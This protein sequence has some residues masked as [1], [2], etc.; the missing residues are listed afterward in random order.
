MIAEEHRGVH[1]AGEDVEQAET[2]ARRREE[3]RIDRRDR[4]AG[5][6]LGEVQ[7]RA[8]RDEHHPEPGL[9]DHRD[10]IGR[11]AHDPRE[12]FAGGCAVDDLVDRRD[13]QVR[14]IAGRDGELTTVAE[15]G[16]ALGERPI[17]RIGGDVRGD[18]GTRPLAVEDRSI[19][20][21]VDEAMEP[22]RALPVRELDDQDLR[23]PRERERGRCRQ[24]V[25]ERERDHP[26]EREACD[27]AIRHHARG[28]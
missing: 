15:S 19:D 14:D 5:H 2:I 12:R 20:D 17:V 11:F 7:L 13:A 10:A 1:L 6:A 21:R 3:L 9:P 24:P 4:F 18:H 25:L 16:A 8:H 26:Q 22:E 27:R 23:N 28:R